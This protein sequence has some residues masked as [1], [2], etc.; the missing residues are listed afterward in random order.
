MTGE[1]LLPSASIT[2]KV[3]SE[4]GLH[5]TFIRKEPDTSLLEMKVTP[6]DNRASIL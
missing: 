1:L 2:Y 5:A 4:P 3:T 6:L